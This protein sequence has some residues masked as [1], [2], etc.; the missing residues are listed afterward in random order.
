MHKIHLTQ[1]RCS[2]DMKVFTDFC[3]EL[4]KLN[5]AASGI[6]S[7][8]FFSSLSVPQLNRKQQC[9][10]DAISSEEFAKALNS[11]GPDGF[12]G[13]FDQTFAEK[14]TPMLL[15]MLK[16]YFLTGRLPDSLYDAHIC[17]GKY[18][19]DP[20]SYRAVTL[21]SLEHKMSRNKTK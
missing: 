20:G 17:K 12:G 8:D 3:T 21:L 4:N 14:L 18:S 11:S 15:R 5:A 1:E 19:L 7:D 16:D 10:L 6:D 9:S 2:Q 13:K